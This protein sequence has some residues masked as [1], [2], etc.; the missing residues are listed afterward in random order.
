MGGGGQWAKASGTLSGTIEGQN[1]RGGSDSMGRRGTGIQRIRVMV[2]ASLGW[3]VPLM[4]CQGLIHQGD[5]GE[6]APLSSAPAPAPMVEPSPA[7][8]DP[9]PAASATD[10]FREGMN[11]ATSAVVLG[12]S[13]QSPADWQLAASRW[14]QAIDLMQQVPPDSPNHA[15]AQAKAQEYRRNLAAAQQRASGQVAAPVSAEPVAPPDGLVAQIPILERRGGIPMVEVTLQG[16]NGVHRFPMMFDTGASGTLITAEMA[17]QIGVVITGST[18]VKIADG[19]T[20]NLP[21]GY[22]DFIEVGGL[23]KTSMIVAVGG[24]VGLLGQDVY[25]E[26]GIALGSHMINLHQ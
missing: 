4:G 21:I 11:R 20:V 8:V 3:L 17:Q 10:Y 2:I 14:Q 9:T 16:Q 24:S 7:P 15:Q 25:G 23:R 22:V 26:F 13:A 1:N 6:T 12:Q 19:S 18:Q 5:G